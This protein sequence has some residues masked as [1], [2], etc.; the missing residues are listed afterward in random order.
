[1]RI[2]LWLAVLGAIAATQL[3]ATPVTFAGAEGNMS[4]AAK[5]ELQ[6]TNLVITLTNK[7][8]VDQDVPADILTALLFSV[9]GSPALTRVSALLPAGAD[10]VCGAGTA[11]CGKPLDNVVGGEWAYKSGLSV[12]TGALTSSYGISSTGVGLFGPGD[13]F[14]GTNL[15]GPDDPNGVQF[16][17]V[18]KAWLPAGDNGGIS[19]SGFIRDSVVFTLS[20]IA[21]NSDLARLVSNVAFQY[22]TDLSEPR[23][24]GTPGRAIENVVPEPGTYALMGAGLVGIFFLKRRAA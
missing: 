12:T 15:Q 4:A 21:N 9:E 13:R 10:V 16:G 14:A 23:I 5:F 20:G 19:G 11:T 17:I 2:G 1:M 8:K 22:G 3:S 6:G 18:S 7:S 24:P